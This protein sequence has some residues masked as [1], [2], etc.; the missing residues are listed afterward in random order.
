MTCVKWC[1]LVAIF[2]VAVN[3][4]DKG[5]SHVDKPM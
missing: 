2:V 5:R 1:P 4:I 3:R